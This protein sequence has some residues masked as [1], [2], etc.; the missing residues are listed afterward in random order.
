MGVYTDVMFNET[1][2]NTALTQML[3]G[4]GTVKG[5]YNPQ[6]N[7]RLVRITVFLTPQAATSLCQQGRI[8]LSQSNWKPNILRFPF[9][10]YGLQTAPAIE[11][12]LQQV[13][14]VVDLPVQTD[15]PITGND[16]FLFS[17]VTPSLA[18]LGYF[19]Y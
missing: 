11:S 4:T 19:T 5:N 6:I 2:A 1:V 7:G 3:A 16:I 9:A 18:I 14:Y 17:P 12:S 13:D 15:W 10:G 8:E